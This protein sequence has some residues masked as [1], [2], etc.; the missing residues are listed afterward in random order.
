MND[1]TINRV[2]DM[3][4]QYGGKFVTVYLA[5]SAV[6]LVFCIA[7]F[8]FIFRAFMKFWNSRDEF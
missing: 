8:V 6:S 2:L 5:F 4:E 1:Q 3:F 7:V